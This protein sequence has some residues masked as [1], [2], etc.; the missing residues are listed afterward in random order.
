MKRCIILANGKAPKKIIINYFLQK[1]NYDLICAD[2]GANTALKLKLTPKIIIGD[3]D[4]ALPETLSFF[5]NDSEII[6]VKRQNDTDVEKCLKYAIKHKYS[7]AVLIGVTG[8]RLDHT[9]CNLGIVLKFANKINVKLAA[10]NSFLESFS[11]GVKIN[12][13]IGEIVSIYGF[14]KTTTILTKG[15]KYPLVNEPLPFGVR[16]STSNV[17]IANEIELFIK[18]GTMFVVRDIY[19]MI[20]NGFLQ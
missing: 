8:D 20:K 11:G 1:L 9:F 16:E 2:G 14:N 17:A 7:E 12:A 13:C 15:L 4:S 19:G 10:E 3:F 5:E 6:Q 18:N